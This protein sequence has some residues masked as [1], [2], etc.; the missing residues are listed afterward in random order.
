MNAHDLISQLSIISDPRQT[1]KVG[2]KL[3][4]ILLLTICGVIAGAEGWEEI[5]DFGHERLEWLKQ[6]G[7]FEEG[8]PSDDTIARVVSNINPKQFQQCF[9]DWM[10]ACHEAAKGD[11]IAID[12]KTVRRSYDKS[13]KRGAIHMI[14]AFSAANN[15]VLGQ[16]KTEEKT[17]EITAIPELLKLLEIKG[18]LVTLDAMGCQR[19]I[20]Q[21]I[22]SKDADYL[23]AV[24]GNQGKLEKAFDHHFSLDKL[25]QWEGDSFM[26]RETGHGRTETRMYFVSDLF[27]EFV[28]FSFDW[29]GMKTLGIALSSREIEGEVLDLNDVCIRYYISSA[30]LT[31]EQLGKASREH[32]YKENK[33]HWKLDVAMREDECR[34]RRND[35]AEVLAGLRHVAVNLLNNTKTFKAGLKRKQKKAA[36]STRYLSEVLAGQGLS[37]SCRGLFAARGGRLIMNEQL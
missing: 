36:L 34:I 23:L 8:I 19:G 16:L 35:G 5:E 7:D 18:C 28:N 17:N 27:D 20:A 13:K 33:L 30:E 22:V 31:A 2:H 4:D 11:V 3:T 32:W 12:G 9:I 15:V 29:P 24:K 26:T 1:W 10:N 6:Y 37:L 21:T 25:N 14:S